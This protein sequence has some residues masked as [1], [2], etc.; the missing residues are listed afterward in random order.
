MRT[1]PPMFHAFPPGARIMFVIT[2]EE[3]RAFHER[4]RLVNAVIDEEIR[5]TPVD[6]KL[7]QLGVMVASAYA[8]GWDRRLAE[9]EEEVRERWR[10][11]KERLHV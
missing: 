9:G 11:L 5:T 1:G 3:A 7:R 10:I 6:V 2:E 8:M 4:W